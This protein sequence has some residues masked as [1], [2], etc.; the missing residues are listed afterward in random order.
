MAVN[1]RV[2]RDAG[3][4]ADPDRDTITVDGRRLTIGATREY[5]VVNKPRGMLSSRSDP[6]GRPVV[7]DLAPPGSGR[8]FPVGRLDGD[9]EGLVLLTD[10][11]D[12]ANRLLH[13]RYEI[14]RVYEVEVR[15]DVGDADLGRWRRG[16]TLEDGPARPSRVRLL[17]RG[18][19]TTCLELTFHEGRKR[20]VKRY[21]Q[22][23]GHRVVRLRRTRFGPIGLGAL[24]PGRGRP[25]TPR[26]RRAL[27]R[28][29]ERGAFPYNTQDSRTDPHQERL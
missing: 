22:A 1:G 16:V 25:L 7:V 6:H 10:D 9:A 29:R 12:L 8:L 18:R 3:A 4:L 28:L 11:G 24:A 19:H 23:L 15:G 21:C 27:G 5:W 17:R 14:P 13:P 2:R 20:E 26:E